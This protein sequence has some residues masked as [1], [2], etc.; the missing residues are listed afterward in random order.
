[1]KHQSGYYS[2][3]CFEIILLTIMMIK[4]TTKQKLAESRICTNQESFPQRVAFLFS[5]L[6][7]LVAGCVAYSARAR[8][9]SRRSQR[10]TVC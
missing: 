2:P 6:C 10:G 3:S 1:M 9:R 7:S 5:V 8:R 4:Q